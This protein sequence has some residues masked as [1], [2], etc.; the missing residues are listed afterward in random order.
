MY[1]V[2]SVVGSGTRTLSYL[3]GFVVIGLAV[4]VTATSLDVGDIAAWAWQVFGITF[5]VLYT[6]LVFI[7]VFAWT[8][9]QQAA[10]ESAG[11]DESKTGWLRRSLKWTRRVYSE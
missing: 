2:F 3:L 6:V 4:V 7:A 10:G 8:R 1:T 11:G 5:L 9:I